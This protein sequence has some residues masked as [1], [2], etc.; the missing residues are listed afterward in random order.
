M[1]TAK[2]VLTSGGRYDARVE[3]WVTPALAWLPARIR[4]TQ[5]S[6]SYIDL[7]LQGQEPLPDLPASPAP[8]D[9]A[10]QK[11]TPS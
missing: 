3:F 5:A 4:I 11:T 2:W 10:V 7:S 1:D 9:G 8:A 6:G